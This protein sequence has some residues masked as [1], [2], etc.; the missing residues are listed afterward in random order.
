[1][2]FFVFSVVSD[3][4]DRQHVHTFDLPAHALWTSLL[5]TESNMAAT[6]RQSGNRIYKGLILPVEIVE[7]LSDTLVVCLEHGTKRYRGVLL[8]STKR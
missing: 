7:A 3:C 8:D 4:V 5:I 6:T 2:Y 1:M